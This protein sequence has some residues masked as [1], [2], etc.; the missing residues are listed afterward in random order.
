MIDYE[1]VIGLE[2]HAQLRTRTKIFCRCEATFGAAPNTRVCATCLGLPGALPALNREAVVM[3]ARAGLALGCSVRR[4]SRFARKNYFYPDLPKGY[5]ISQYDEPLCEEGA[6]DVPLADGSLR[7]VRIQRVHLEEDAGKNLHGAGS[8]SN[9]TL[10]DLNRAGVPLIEIVGHPDLRTAAEAAEYLRQ[11]RTV[12]M[13]VGVNDGNLEAGTF[14]CDANVS[15]RPRGHSTLGARVEIKNVNSFRFVQKAIEWEVAEQIATLAAGGRIAQVTKTWDDT[16]HRCVLLRSK[17]TSEDYR[18]FPDP[19]LCPIVLDEAF[20]DEMRASLPALPAARRARYEREWGVSSTDARVITEHPKLAE[21]FEHLVAQSH[22]PR[23]AAAWVCNA[24]KTG[25]ESNGLDARFAVT[26]AQLAGLFARLDD[27]TL[28]SKLAK[29]AYAQM[30]HTH[31]SVDVVIA[32]NG[33]SVLRDDD[34][35]AAVCGAVLAANEKQLAAYRA[36]K[37]A[38]AG[39]FKGEVMKRTGGRADPQVLDRVLTAL[40][41]ATEASNRS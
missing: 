33:W 11:L 13:F 10:V 38:L 39:Y 41:D 25:F 28:S 16:A 40:L 6:L 1:P 22:D 26:V 19:D 30:A 7:R 35:V 9:A 14:R 4:V 21:F 15:V 3:G 31:D 27:G 37:K 20:I 8:T 12:L 32:R 29:D 18:Y 24:I 17:E 36:G 2:V 5:Q 23:R 34:A